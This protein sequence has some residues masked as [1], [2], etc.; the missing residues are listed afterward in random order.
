[1]FPEKREPRRPT[2]TAR[3][4]LVGKDTYNLTFVGYYPSEH[5]RVAFSVVVPS[6]RDDHDPVSKNIAK[7]AI[8]A[9]KELEKKYNKNNK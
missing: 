1:M 9:Y 6:V 7:G 2:I 5:P 8:D 3:T 4:K